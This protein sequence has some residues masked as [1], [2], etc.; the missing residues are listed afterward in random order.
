MDEN[1]L[2]KFQTVVEGFIFALAESEQTS[3]HT[4]AT[5]VMNEGENAWPPWPWPPWG[6]EDG[7]TDKDKEPVDRRRRAHKLAK[8]VV[9]LERRLANASLDL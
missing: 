6:D 2:S 9:K 4:S 7:D 1:M 5:F 3:Q 8:Q